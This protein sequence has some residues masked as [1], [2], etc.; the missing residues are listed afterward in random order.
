MKKRGIR[1]FIDRF[2][3]PG[4]LKSKTA[5]YRNLKQD[6]KS[7]PHSAQQPEGGNAV[8][9][10]QKTIRLSDMKNMHITILGC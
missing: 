3:E 7:L 10:Q 4:F 9:V 1:T 2:M 6:D 5:S 8:L